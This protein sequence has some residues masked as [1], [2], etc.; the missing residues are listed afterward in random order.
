MSA[1]RRVA[2]VVAAASLATSSLEAQVLD[3]EG[4]PFD[5][6]ACSGTVGNFYN[7][8]AGTDYGIE[9]S[10]NALML[11]LKN[12]ALQCANSNTSRGG[13]GDPTSQGGGLFF[14]TGSST[15]MNN[16][17]GFGTGFSFFYSAINLGGSFDVW[18]G[19]NGTGTNLGHLDLAVTPSNPSALPGCFGAQFCPFF[20]AGISFLGTAQSVTFSGVDNQI[21]FD[22]VTFGS[23]TPGQPGQVTPEPASMALLGTGLLGLGLVARRRRMNA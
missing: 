12:P 4:I 2:V 22:D 3:F 17:A 11:S 13:L 9:F 20:A 18:S 5:P 1:F 7:G 19:L 8:G 21:V 14:L 10:S 16:A 15:Y 23:A 6:I